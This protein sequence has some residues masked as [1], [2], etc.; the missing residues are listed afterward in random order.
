MSRAHQAR[1]KA[2][3]KERHLLEQ[4]VERAQ[5]ARQTRHK[6][7]IRIGEVIL[8]AATVAVV[9]ILIATAV[10]DISRA[11]RHQSNAPLEKEISSLLS[12]IPQNGA[13]LGQPSA[14]ITLQVFGD[15]ESADTR[16][17][18]MWLL[19]N[20]IRRWVR[21]NIIKVQYR[22]FMTRSTPSQTVFMNQQTA[23]L[24]AGAQNK[25]WNFIETFYYKQ[26]PERTSYVTENYLHDIATQIPGL[27]LPEWESDRE[28]SQL[29]KQVVNDNHAAQAIGFPDSP[30][31][32]IGKTGGKFAPLPSYR[33]YEEPGLKAGFTRR[34][35]NPLSF[36]TSKDL[37]RLIERL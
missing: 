16:T 10:G 22:S 32:L 26:G 3:R 15:L 21:T 27:E 19:P 34:P 1:L 11:P 2:K 25:L 23:A 17:F 9:G 20:I 30:L 8:V 29:A 13:T 28:L 36:V 18:V 14:P 37:R 33:L 7:V 35:S 5:I 4:A 31:F 24:A 6:A 12:G